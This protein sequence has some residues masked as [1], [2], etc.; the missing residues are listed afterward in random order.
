MG[1]E[2]IILSIVAPVYNEE[3]N[4]EEVVRYWNKVLMNSK[5]TGEIVVTNDGSTDR[6]G[7][8]LSRLEN[9][10]ANLVV[11]NKEHGGYGRALAA[12]VSAS[13][14]RY[15]MT[16]DSDG[17]FDAGEYHLLLTKLEEE[18]LDLVT[19][20]RKGKKDSLFKVV[21][22]RILNLI[23]RILFGLRLKDTNCAL[24]LGK[25]E[26]LRKIDI[27]AMGYPTPTEIIIKLAA[28]GASLGEVGISHLPRA[29]GISKLRPVKTAIEMLKFL[30][31]LKF[32]LHLSKSRVIAKI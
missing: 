16:I 13:R 9:E 28:S 30:L 2:G 1:S 7:D 23:I 6:T 14:G 5:L 12:S 32:K 21:A 24:K 15:V 17:Q 3:R 11:I 25:G 27:E 19:G 10:L 18:N 31:Y 22:D 4:I 29:G 26:I 20:Y 8:I